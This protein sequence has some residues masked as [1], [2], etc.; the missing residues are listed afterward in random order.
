MSEWFTPLT[1][2]QLT[3]HLLTLVVGGFNPLEAYGYEIEWLIRANFVSCEMVYNE[4]STQVSCGVCDGTASV[5]PSGAVSPYNY[6]WFTTPSQTTPT[7]TGLCEGT[8]QV[9]IT[10]N[11][12]CERGTTVQV[13][14]AGGTI[15]LSTSVTPENCGSGDGTATATATGG[16]APYTFTW[17]GSAQ[18]AGTITGLSVGTYSVTATDIG[19]CSVESDFFNAAVVSDYIPN[20]TITGTSTDEICVGAN[21]TATASASG[22]GGSYTYVWDAS[23]GSQVT[24]T[25]TGLGT[26]TYS[27]TTTDVY[28]CVGS[29]TVTVANNPGTFTASLTITNTTT[30]GGTDGSA[31]GIPSGGNAPYS[32][33]WDN[34]STS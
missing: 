23:A 26:A 14:S 29:G 1:F 11:R 9:L 33:I 25:A 24:T 6:N 3:Q 22:G 13:T 21:G 20:I 2:T 5:A 18:T 15:L 8:Y 32:Y 17:S 31:T 16:T 34:A 19:G 30:V 7:A 28:G 27:V 10:D 4:S 12:G